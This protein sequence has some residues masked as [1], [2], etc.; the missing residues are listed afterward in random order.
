MRHLLYTVILSALCV[1]ILA[2]QSPENELQQLQREYASSTEAWQMQYNGVKTEDG[3]IARYREWPGWSFAPKFISFAEEAG[4]SQDGFDALLEVLKMGDSVGQFDQDLFDHYE[5]AIKLILEKHRDKE[6]RTLCAKVRVSKQSESLLRTLMAEGDSKELRAEACFR[7]GRLLSQKR[8]MCLPSSWAKRP[9]VGSFGKYADSRVRKNLDQFLANQ[10]IEQLQ[11]EAIRCFELVASD[12]PDVLSTR[13]D[14]KLSVRARREI[15]ELEH[16]AIGVAA[17]DIVGADIDGKQMRLSDNRGKVVL[18]VFWASWCGPCIG[19]IPH[20]KELYAKFAD[21]PFVIV[22]VNADDTLKSAQLSV[23]ENAIPWRSFWNGPDGI[24]GPI[25]TNWNVRAWP[26]VYVLDSEGT[27]RFKHLR[28]ESLDGPL[29]QLLN[30]TEL[31][32]SRQR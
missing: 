11:S 14:E 13:G 25:T 28:R 7:L 4:S 27:I 21:R 32:I 18:L 22:G 8:E 30:E 24:D 3:S 29:D 5:H 2:A 15:F 26:T 17:P 6:L 31:K 12:Y 16:L 10:D 9:S 20:E 1:G 19:D 23:S